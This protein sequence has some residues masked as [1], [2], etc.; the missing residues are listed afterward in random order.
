VKVVLATGQESLKRSGVWK[1][2]QRNI[3]TER[4]RVR[5]ADLLDGLGRPTDPI[6]T[7]DFGWL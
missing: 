3:E 7:Y 2:S 5:S 4:Q 1:T 6:A